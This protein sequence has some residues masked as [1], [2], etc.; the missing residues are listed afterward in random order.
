MRRYLLQ[1]TE[2]GRGGGGGELRGTRKVKLGA[3]N[4]PL[5]C[6]DCSLDIFS[7]R[8]FS[9]PFRTV[10]KGLN[11]RQVKQN[12]PK[13][14]RTVLDYPSSDGEEVSSWCT[15]VRIVRKLKKFGYM[16]ND[17]EESRWQK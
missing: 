7:N 12:R 15:M 14:P 9:A 1:K 6:S 4:E 11:R 10:S 8:S 16:D 17:N 3:Q 13:P 2:G 5:P